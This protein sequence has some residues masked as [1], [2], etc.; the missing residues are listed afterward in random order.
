MSE[1]STI[2]LSIDPGAITGLCL[3]KDGEIIK[4]G[5]KK[6]KGD[7]DKRLKQFYNWLKSDFLYNPIDMIVFEE[8][9]Y[10]WKRATQLFEYVGAIKCICFEWNKEYK[11]FYPAEIKEAITGSGRS[12][13]EDVRI[14]VNLTYDLDVQSYDEADA[15]AIMH[16]HVS[17]KEWEEK[18]EG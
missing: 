10:K 15:I 9:I 17:L 3:W 1:D 18:L 8:P 12:S 14:S 7:H 11:S 13:K 4:S 6:W 2:I 16:A 5:V